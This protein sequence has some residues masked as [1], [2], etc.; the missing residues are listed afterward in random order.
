MK[1]SIKIT[2]CLTFLILVVFSFCSNVTSY[3][4]NSVDPSSLPEHTSEFYIN[5]FANILDSDTKSYILSNSKVLDDATTAQVVVATV[6]S[7]EGYSID[8]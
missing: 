2:A 8:D 7:L 4:G 1:K 3:A 6:K 5:D